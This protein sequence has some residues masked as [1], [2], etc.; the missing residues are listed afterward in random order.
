MIATVL[1]I[2]IIAA[3][4]IFLFLFALYLINKKSPQDTLDT[5]PEPVRFRELG[6]FSA[7]LDEVQWDTATK[8]EELVVTPAPSVVA[9]GEKDTAKA[10]SAKKRT[11]KPS[12]TA[13]KVTKKAT[14]KKAP[15]KKTAPKK[16]T[17][18]GKK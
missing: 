6:D 14:T 10:A 9:T 18:A 17:S 16:R 15:V 1:Q 4:A 8:V 13:K 11:K 5:P 3:C 2:A 7:F 12:T